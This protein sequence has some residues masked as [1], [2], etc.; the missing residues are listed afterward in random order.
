MNLPEKIKSENAAAKA[1]EKKR[2]ALTAALKQKAEEN[3]PHW[4]E[5]DI[6]NFV[7]YQITLTE[8]EMEQSENQKLSIKQIRDIRSKCEFLVALSKNGCHFGNAAAFAN[9]ARF[10]AYRWLKTDETFAELYDSATASA[11]DNV[12]TALY[13][14]ALEGNVTAQI[15]FL[16]A[17]RP[18]VWNRDKAK[19]TEKTKDTLEKPVRYIIDDD[20]EIPMDL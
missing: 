17:K 20:L 18:E 12:E 6:N 4:S 8:K 7:R 9:I 19:E 3:Y 11:V 16:K 5:N 10:T 1:E 2:N 15:A 13:R 14:S